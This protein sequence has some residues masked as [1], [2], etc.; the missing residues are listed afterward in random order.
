MYIKEEVP[1]LTAASKTF[2]FGNGRYKTIVSSQ[3]LNV[4][5]SSG[6]WVEINNTFIEE[7]DGAGRFLRNTENIALDV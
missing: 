2:D 7:K 3:T 5:D 6:K 1:L 4:K